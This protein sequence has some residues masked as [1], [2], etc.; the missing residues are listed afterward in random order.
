MPAPGRPDPAE[1]WATQGGYDLIHWLHGPE[2][3]IRLSLYAG[4][5][6]RDGA[7]SRWHQDYWELWDSIETGRSNHAAA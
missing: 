2:V 6:Q 5:W 3:A 4:L 1:H 7:G